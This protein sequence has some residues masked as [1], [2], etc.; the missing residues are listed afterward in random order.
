MYIV[1]AVTFLHIHFV[2]GGRRQR[3]H[4]KFVKYI[5]N[6]CFKRYEVGYKYLFFTLDSQ[7][8]YCEMV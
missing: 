1:Y 5:F 4:E 3:E 7:I 6:Y 2:D 8:I